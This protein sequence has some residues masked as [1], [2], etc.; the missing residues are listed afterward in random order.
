MEIWRVLTVE[1]NVIDL[2]PLGGQSRVEVVDGEQRFSAG[3]V[4][5]SGDMADDLAAD[6]AMAQVINEG[7]FTQTRQAFFDFAMYWNTPD[8]MQSYAQE[9][10][11]KSYIPDV[12]L[13]KVQDFLA[14]SSISAKVSI[15]RKM[16]I[17]RYQKN[18]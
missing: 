6:N 18:I 13:A 10:W 16:M 8:E 5:E 7:Q 17:T 12:V 1:G 2:R 11:Q 4:D 15:R 3:L 9:R 14:R